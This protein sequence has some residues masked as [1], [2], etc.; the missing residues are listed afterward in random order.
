MRRVF[1]TELES[2]DVPI[3]PDTIIGD[4]LESDR[5]KYQVPE[6]R[7]VVID[8]R[9]SPGPF[10]TGNLGSSARPLA[11]SLETF[12]QAIFASWERRQGATFI[13]AGTGTSPMSRPF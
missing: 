6:S 5:Q 8:G 12:I 2:V 1:V 7:L 9:R 10:T 4:D 3:P 11:I 13:A